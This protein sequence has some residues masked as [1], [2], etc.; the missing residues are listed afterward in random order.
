MQ[1]KHG[2]P[3]FSSKSHPMPAQLKQKPSILA[4]IKPNHGISY[5][6][7]SNNCTGKIVKGKMQAY[8]QRS[9]LFKQKKTQNTL[10]R[11]LPQLITLYYQE[12]YIIKQPGDRTFPRKQSSYY[13]FSPI[14]RKNFPQSAGTGNK[15]VSRLLFHRE[16]RHL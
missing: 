11:F 14:T 5:M 12:I 8:I 16:L 15:C 4:L 9:F 13:S 1:K 7:L 6:L 10:S 2:I 3:Q